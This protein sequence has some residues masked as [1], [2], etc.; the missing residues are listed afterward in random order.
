LHAVRIRPFAPSELFS[1][2]WRRQ[3]C[4]AREGS[5]WGRSGQRAVLKLLTYKRCSAWE[6]SRRGRTGQP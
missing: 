6:G 2:C 3:F 4:S 1:V 5:R